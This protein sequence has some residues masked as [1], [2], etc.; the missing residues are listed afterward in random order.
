MDEINS[1]T[2]V[3]YTRWDYMDGDALVCSSLGPA[4]YGGLCIFNQYVTGAVFLIQCVWV[5]WVRRLLGQHAMR[6]APGKTSPM[7]QPNDTNRHISLL[8]IALFSA[9]LE[10]LV[11][12]TTTRYS[13]STFEGLF[14]DFMYAIF[15]ATVLYHQLLQL[16][17]AENF[18]SLVQDFGTPVNKNG[19]VSR[20]INFAQSYGALPLM[21]SLWLC[22]AVGVI[23][24][25]SYHSAAVI[26]MVTTSAR[27]VLHTI[28]Y[29]VR[30]L[31]HVNEM[32]QKAHGDR[33]AKL[34]RRGILS[35]KLG[36][37]FVSLVQCLVCDLSVVTRSTVSVYVSFVCVS[38]QATS[39]MRR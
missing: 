23:S 2:L 30:A 11:G 31:S 26:A 37:V 25:A 14:S 18:V 39:L 34:R 13:S 33:E 16:R 32:Q 1:S 38:G 9:G 12:G 4:D 5:L 24:R 36:Y 28:S 3:G 35:V 21:C 17:T 20:V 22:M 7:P 15:S 19:W 27:T 10:H 6:V 8:A 29:R